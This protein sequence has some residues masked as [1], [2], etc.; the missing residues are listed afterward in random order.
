M[1]MLLFVIFAYYPAGKKQHGYAQQTPDF[2][3][4]LGCALLGVTPGQA[5]GSYFYLEIPT[6]ESG[7]IPNEGPCVCMCVWSSLEADLASSTA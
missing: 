3:G 7:I 1:M 5:L 2:S 6:V 4:Y